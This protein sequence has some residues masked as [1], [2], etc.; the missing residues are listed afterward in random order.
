MTHSQ[1]NPLGAVV[2]ASTVETAQP[3]ARHAQ[4]IIWLLAASV[5]L[6]MTGFG[7]IMPIFAHRLDEFGD[8][9]AE[10][11][12][13]TMAF[14]LTQLMAAP[15]MGTWGDKWGRRP[16]ILIALLAFSLTNI[17]YLVAESTTLFILVRALG[18]LFIAGLFPSAMGVVADITPETRRAQWIG[19]VMG[20]YGAGFIFGPVLGGVLY[21]GF[22]FAA[23]FIVSSVLAFLAFVA[24]FF[25]VPETRGKPVR[26]REMLRRRR[27]AAISPFDIS[28]WRSLPRPL[29]LFV[30]LLFI[31]FIG[32]FVFAFIEPQMVFFLYNELGWSTTQFGMVVGVYGLAMVVGQTALGVTSDKVGRKPVIIVGLLLSLL[33]YTALSFL[34]S[35]PLIIGSAILAGL[36]VALIAPASNA[37]YLDITEEQHRG[38]IV[39]IKES[40]LAL[41]GVLGPLLV[42]FVSRWTTPQGVFL[43]A[44]GLVVV[45]AL[46]ASICLRSL[47]K[48]DAM[49]TELAWEIAQQR[50]L[51]AQAAISGLVTNARSVRQ[52]RRV[53]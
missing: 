50:S 13:M 38:R 29:I 5:A 19:I 10:L 44:G 48:Q 37:F 39:G 33:L 52:S 6:M 51:A 42:I 35:F 12:L 1:R 11:G 31:D 8:G 15:F 18:G 46:L 22:G 30:T 20:G 32:A 26:Y 53:I 34:R 14:A 25:L 7:I 17:G 40:F 43:T 3:S 45:T 23:P 27:E 24:A 21:D 41:G 4:L 2:I 28:I 36:G 47:P 9:V 49:S 16:F